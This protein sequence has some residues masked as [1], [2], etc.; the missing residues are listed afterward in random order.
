MSKRQ[1]LIIL[2]VWVMVFLF[3]GFPTTWDKVLSLVTGV[4]IIVVA[5]KFKP[6][7]REILPEHLS[8]IEHKSVK[9]IESVAKPIDS[10]K[11]QTTITSPTLANP[12]G[13]ITSTD[14]MAS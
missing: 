11:Q 1:F 13:T 8:Y 9:P 14:A 12:T 6:A 10:S 7:T 4:L 3:L 5:S 2:G